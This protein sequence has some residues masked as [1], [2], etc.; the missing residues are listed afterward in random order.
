MALEV[1][2]SNPPNRTICMVIPF[3]LI[4]QPIGRIEATCGKSVHPPGIRSTF[5]KLT[6]PGGVS[7]AGFETYP[8]DQ[9]PFLP[10]INFIHAGTR[11]R[12]KPEGPRAGLLWLVPGNLG[13]RSHHGSGNGWP[14]AAGDGGW[15]PAALL[16]PVHLEL[17]FS[18]R[19]PIRRLRKRGSWVKQAAGNGKKAE[20]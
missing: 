11:C 8:G 6:G 10:R 15:L 12:A 17:Q 1:G 16:C 4:L 20:G 9:A 3:P 18:G 2:G 7:G 19:H 14:M 5:P 13:F